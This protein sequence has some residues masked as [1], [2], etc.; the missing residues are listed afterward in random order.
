MTARLEIT[1]ADEDVFRLLK[2]IVADPACSQRSLAQAAQMSLG[3]TNSLLRSMA[4][5][6]LLSISPRSGSAARPVYRITRRGITFCA[7]FGQP[8][9]E[10]R[11]REM[12]ALKLEIEAMERMPAIVA[13]GEDRAN[14]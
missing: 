1:A 5:R 2:G 13:R 14:R 7:R 9:L 3:R 8:Y 10:R 11:R 6:G 12:V 4:R